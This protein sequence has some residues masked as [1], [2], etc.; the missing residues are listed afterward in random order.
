MGNRV[1]AEI[2]GRKW[3]AR[4]LIHAYATDIIADKIHIEKCRS[5]DLNLTCGAC[6]VAHVPIHVVQVTRPKGSQVLHELLV[7]EGTGFVRVHPVKQSRGCS[8]GVVNSI[9]C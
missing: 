2:A 6:V 5:T 7:I 9:S 1:H 3:R 4:V 8:S